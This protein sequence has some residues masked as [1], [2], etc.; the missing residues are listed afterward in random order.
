MT[1]KIR[2]LKKLVLNKEALRALSADTL[3]QVLGGEDD[4]AAPVSKHLA[5]HCGGDSEDLS[6]CEV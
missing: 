6:G 2:K 4:A 3:R 1:K 5:K